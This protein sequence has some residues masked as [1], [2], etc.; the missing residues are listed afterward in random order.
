[1]S[2]LTKREQTENSAPN[3]STAKQILIAEDEPMIRSLLQRLLNLWGYRTLVASNGK[4]ALELEEQHPGDVDLLLSDVTMPEMNGP[5]LAD[6][7]TKKRPGLKVILMSGYSYA[8][9][10]LRRGWKFIQKPF[11]PSDIKETI[12]EVL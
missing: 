10:T 6:R 5:E 11:K 4:Q 1:M 2:E 12:N 7:L 9:V 3:D 8:Q